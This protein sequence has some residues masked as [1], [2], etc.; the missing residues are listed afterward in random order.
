MPSAC[1]KCCGG[2]DGAAGIAKDVGASRIA[3]LECG[4]G[5]IVFSIDPQRP[6]LRRTPKAQGRKK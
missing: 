3:L 1:G 6:N 2:G 4:T 5:Q